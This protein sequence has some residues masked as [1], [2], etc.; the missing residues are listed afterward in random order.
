MN[1]RSRV[2]PLHS[3]NHSAHRR[4]G[5]SSQNL[6]SGRRYRH[7]SS[8]EYNENDIYGSEQEDE[9][10]EDISARMARAR[11]SYTKKKADRRFE[12]Q[13][14]SFDDSRMN[15]AA[16]A[17]AAPRAA[18]YKTKMGSNH[19]KAARMQQKSSG[20]ATRYRT[21]SGF[22]A[23]SKRTRRFPAR[24]QIVCLGVIAFVVIGCAV[25]YAPAQQY[26]Q[27]I[28]ERD[29]LQAEYEAVQARNDYIQD[30]IDILSTDE[31]VADKARADL[32]WIE[33]GETLGSVSGLSSEGES[34]FVANI[35][36]GSIEAPETWYS[37][38]LDPLF[39]VD[40]ASATGSDDSEQTDEPD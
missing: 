9:N 31:G 32:G 35:I 19:R 14:G 29:R 38:I 39:N 37:R 1:T 15:N 21:R 23:T 27:E 33:P 16:S 12:R 2:I 3:A 11:R 30:Q 18:V 6:Q 28:R 10:S 40:S 13:Y 7:P 26:Y 17:K 20:A 22:N 4:V 25:L 34:D 8:T 24:W 5:S 36:P